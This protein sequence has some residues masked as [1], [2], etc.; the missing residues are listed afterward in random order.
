MKEYFDLWKEKN[1][2]QMSWK[3]LFEWMF[4]SICFLPETIDI[5]EVSTDSTH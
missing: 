3:G 2:V 5:E 1:V 4:Q